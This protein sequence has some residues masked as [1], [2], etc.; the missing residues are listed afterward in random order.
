VGTS[1]NQSSPRSANWSAA[2]TGYRANIP[3]ERIV[4]EVWRAATNQ[5]QGNLAKL[6]AQP[7][8]ARLGQLGVEG[9]TPTQVASA[10]SREIAR[11]KASSLA[12]DI[13]QRAAVQCLSSTDR[14]QAYGERLFAEAC[15]YLVSR[16][17]PGFIGRANRNQ[18]IVEAL[19]FKSSVLEDTARAVHEGGR[20]DF[21]TTES[22]RTYVEG[23]VHHLKRR[24]T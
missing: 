22:W 8:V 18:T 20:P 14:A 1:V 2:Q 10:T 6:L 12:T 24:T 17:L 4:Q 13:A 15:N 16:D 9:T 3:I 21:S 23:I 5:P 7:I 11:S 19:A